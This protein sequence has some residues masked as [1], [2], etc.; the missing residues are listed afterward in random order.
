MWVFGSSFRLPSLERLV[1]PSVCEFQYY[2]QWDFC[3]VGLL[4]SNRR[5]LYSVPPKRSAQCAEGQ[6]QKHSRWC[7]LKPAFILSASLSGLRSSDDPSNQWLQNNANEGA[8]FVPQNITTL[9]DLK[10]WLQLEFPT[11]SDAQVQ[12][13]LDAYPSTDAP[14]DAN[15]LKFA[16]DGYGPATAVNVSQVAT[17]PQQ[18]AFVRTDVSIRLLHNPTTYY[19]KKLTDYRIFMQKPPSFVPHTG[20]TMRTHPRTT[21]NTASPSHHTATT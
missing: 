18:R 21:T 13:V 15:S 10:L 4:A 20:S 8:L 14:V 17:G 2:H 6:W 3:N 7:Q 5:I 1:D 9:S 12:Q 11:F 19:D 16:T